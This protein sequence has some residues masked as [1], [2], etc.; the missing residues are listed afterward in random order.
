MASFRIEWALKHFLA[1]QN[2]QK[3]GKIRKTSSE[4]FP[5]SNVHWIPFNLRDTHLE[6]WKYIFMI[7][8]L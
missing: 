4:L 3:W 2:L 7:C 5:L 8:Q 6:S 1:E